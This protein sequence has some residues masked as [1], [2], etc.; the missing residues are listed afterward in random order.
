M[1]DT[2]VGYDRDKDES[3]PKNNKLN[4]KDKMD[5]VDNHGGNDAIHT[6]KEQLV[7]TK[8]EAKDKYLMS[9][10]DKIFMN[11]KGKLVKYTHEYENKLAGDTNSIPRFEKE[12]EGMKIVC[13]RLTTQNICNKKGMNKIKIQMFLHKARCYPDDFEMDQF[14]LARLKFINMTDANSCLD[15]LCRECKDK[16]HVYIDDRSITCK[17]VISDWP[18]SIPELWDTIVDKGNIM[19]IERMT[20]KLFDKKKQSRIE[21]D[22]DN[23]CIIFNKNVLP[24]NISIFEGYGHL[25]VRPYVEAV[26]QCFRCFRFGHVKAVCKGSEKCGRC[27]N[28]AHDECN[29]EYYCINCEGSHR[30]T[31]R[32]CPVFQWNREVKVVMAYHNATFYEAQRILKGKENKTTKDYDRFTKPSDWPELKTYAKVVKQN[33]IVQKKMDTK[34]ST[35]Y[36]DAQVGSKRSSLEKNPKALKSLVNRREGSPNRNQLYYNRFNMRQEE[37]NRDKRGIA[38]RSTDDKSENESRVIKKRRSNIDSH[39]TNGIGN[40]F[41]D[42]MSQIAQEEVKNS[43]RDVEMLDINNGY[44]NS[45][46]NYDRFYDKEIKVYNQEPVDQRNREK[47]NRSQRFRGPANYRSNYG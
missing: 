31:F 11:I 10:K 27:G 1:L 35:Q 41:R 6:M 39:E 22:T 24:N 37:I 42:I 33:P 9:R 19:Q 32:G 17:G 47:S 28:E 46:D 30:S 18:F 4:E 5:L 15:K 40:F 43:L 38:I 8:D 2:N 36:E 21:N 7:N 26:K 14:N 16:V 12:F 29:L 34:K 13:C 45:D 25:K 44:S 3:Q 20:R 23:I